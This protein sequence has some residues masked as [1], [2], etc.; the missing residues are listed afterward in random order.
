MGYSCKHFPPPPHF[1][2]VH[3]LGAMAASAASSHFW[4]SASFFGVFAGHQIFSFSS[5]SMTLHADPSFERHWRAAFPQ[6]SS[7]SESSA[8]AI[9]GTAKAE[10]ASPRKI[11]NGPSLVARA[12]KPVRARSVKDQ[13]GAYTHLRSDVDM[14]SPNSFGLVP[15][16]RRSRGDSVILAHM[17]HLSSPLA[18]DQIR[19]KQ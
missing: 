14:P 13:H 16:N 19:L 18:W 17:I 11:L 8:T 3:S 10:K 6:A 2:G 4:R 9:A 7:P 12:P 15:K 1:F 5:F